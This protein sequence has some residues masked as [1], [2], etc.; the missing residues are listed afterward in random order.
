MQFPVHLSQVIGQIRS[1]WFLSSCQILAVQQTRGTETPIVQSICRNE[2]KKEGLG[3][4]SVVAYK[5]SLCG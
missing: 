4:V 3:A 1:D 2:W 5:S